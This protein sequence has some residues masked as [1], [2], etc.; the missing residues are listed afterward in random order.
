MLT[1]IFPNLFLIKVQI[2]L[3]ILQ[4]VKLQS[5]SE[6]KLQSWPENKKRPTEHTSKVFYTRIEKTVW[7]R[8]N[9]EPEDG[10]KRGQ[11]D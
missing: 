3:V 2:R 7:Y 1:V 11:Y 4:I 5:Y 10:L 8:S 6:R 9:M